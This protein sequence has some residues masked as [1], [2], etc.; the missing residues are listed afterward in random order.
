MSTLQ[1]A[2]CCLLLLTQIACSRAPTP[3]PPAGGEG[4][5]LTF[6]SEGMATWSACLLDPEGFV[7][8]ALARMDLD[9]CEEAWEAIGPEARA[10]LIESGRIHVDRGCRFRRGTGQAA[11]AALRSLG[12]PVDLNLATVED[13]QTLPGVGPALA[14]RILASR[15]VE[16]PFCSVDALARVRGIGAKTLEAL[17]PYLSARCA[18]E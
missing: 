7:P 1:A 2:S 9:R 5:C 15:H 11:A 17:E 18:E 6:S 14:E 3:P 8:E 10:A 13:L 4:T 16:G 12:R